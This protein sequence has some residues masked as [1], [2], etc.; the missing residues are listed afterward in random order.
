M[1]QHAPLIIDIA[2]LDL[3][4]K[5]RQRLKD[6]GRGLSR[7]DIR[8]LLYMLVDVVIQCG[9][10]YHQRFISEIWYAPE[11]RLHGIGALAGGTLQEAAANA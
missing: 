7:A 2:G 11:R 9:V 10:E 1:T 6:G 8:S 3:T 4:A 5:D